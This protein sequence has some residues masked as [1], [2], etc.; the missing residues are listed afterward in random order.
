MIKV[1][2]TGSNGFIGSHLCNKL[3]LRGQKFEISQLKREWF[4]NKS[5]LDLFVSNCDVIVH[6]A[7]I[8][9]NINDRVIYDTNLLL[10]NELIN[11]FNRTSFNG[12]LLFSSS[13]QEER[14][15]A[16]GNSKKVASQLFSNWVEGT[17]G[18][19]KSLIIPNVFGPF[20]RPFYNSVIS[21]FCHQLVN[22]LTPNVISNASLNLVYIDDLVNNI[23]KLIEYESEEIDFIKL[24]QT[25]KVSEILDLLLM[26][27]FTYFDNGHIPILNSKFEL[28]LFNTFRSYIDIKNHFPIKYKNNV[29]V[30]GNFVEIMRLKLGGQISLSTTKK[31][32]TRGN[33][34]HTRKI[35]RFIVVQG[36]ARIQL[37]KIG[38]L[39]IFEYFLCGDEP[40]Y[41]DMPIYYSHN[42]TNIGEED[43]LTLFWINE[44][45]DP[46]DPD[47]YFEKV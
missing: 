35:E 30:R 42:I 38:T 26:F 6:L 31:G 36:K 32:V 24:T 46:K 22:N 15:N 14:N 34:L 4:Q 41:I 29:D 9:R 23:I 12:L 39:E 18:K 5:K 25:F 11:S 28:N 16:F 1:G 2:I 33:H 47:T 10:A 45:Y 7:G 27:K 17:K 44:F 19:F 20:G 3:T 13:I 37:R 43:L 21:T 8:N 40:A